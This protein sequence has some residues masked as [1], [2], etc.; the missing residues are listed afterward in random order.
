MIAAE[1]LPKTI[2]PSKL[3]NIRFASRMLLFF[4]SILFYINSS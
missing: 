4:I 3:K 2:I 1:K